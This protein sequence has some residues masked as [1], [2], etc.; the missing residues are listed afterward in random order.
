MGKKGQHGTVT[1][2]AFRGV[3]RLR[4]SYAGKRHCL[5]LGMPDN[6]VNYVVAQAKAK[7]IEGDLVTGNFDSTLTKYK[8]SQV[9]QPTAI[10]ATDL[11]HRFI[12]HKRRSLYSRSLA[13]IKALQQPIDE[14]FKVKSAGSVAFNTGI[15][16][17]ADTP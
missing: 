2:E 17:L 12:E 8:P 15:H 11:L 5:S 4:W 3:L 13:R 9:Q 14:F 7:V 6:R 10:S 1:I 16:T